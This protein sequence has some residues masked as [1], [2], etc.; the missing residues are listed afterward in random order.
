LHTAFDPTSFELGAKHPHLPWHLT[1]HFQE[2]PKEILTRRESPQSLQ[3]LWLNNIKEVLH[4]LTYTDETSSLR[5]GSAKR[6]FTSP[7]TQISSLYQSLLDLDT[8]TFTSIYQPLVTSPRHI[9]LR[10]FLPPPH[11][12]ITPVV[13]PMISSVESQT[14]GTALHQALPALFP[15]RRT[16]LFARPICH[17]VV[18]PMTANLEELAEIFCGGDGWLDIIIL[19]M[20]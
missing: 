18:I 15:S 1:I 3:D 12:P 4:F 9:P 19:M 2:Y 20:N 13:S 10:V 17:G 14:I 6:I 16:C 7:T 5:H 8:V 11:P